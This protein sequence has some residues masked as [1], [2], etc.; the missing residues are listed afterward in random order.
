MA[1]KFPMFPA[2]L[3]LTHAPHLVRLGRRPALVGSVY[4]ESVPGGYNYTGTTGGGGPTQHDNATG[5][6]G[7]DWG[8]AGSG[9]GN[10]F[11]F[12][13]GGGSS[14]GNP[15]RGDFG[16]DSYANQPTPIA[17]DGGV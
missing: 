14:D 8:D 13:V 12:G 7:S 17:H 15:D 5:N 11:E 6:G 9:E 4:F 16:G 10:G 3:K 1:T 2:V